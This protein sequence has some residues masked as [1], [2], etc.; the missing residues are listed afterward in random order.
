MKTFY[1]LIILFLVLPLIIIQSCAEADEES[2]E[3]PQISGVYFN[4]GDTI[5]WNG[6]IITI[7]SNNN[8]DISRIDT[9]PIGKMAY[10]RAHITGRASSLSSYIVV[11]DSVINAHYIDSVYRFRRAGANI[12]GL[13]DTLIERQNLILIP[14]FETKLNSQTGRNDTIYTHQGDYTM[15]I[16]AGTRFNRRDSLTY[17]V[18]VFSRDSIYKL[19]NGIR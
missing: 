11:L 2:S 6:Q 4:R 10:V 5:D 16:V 15:K 8:D 14:A 12:F 3:P 9:I 7:N 18:K 1:F 13:T 19:K 17:T